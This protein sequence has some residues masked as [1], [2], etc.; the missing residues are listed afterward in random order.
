VSTLA[1]MLVRIRWF[2]L[3]AAVSFGGGM[4]VLGHLVRLRRRLTPANVA[5]ASGEAAAAWLDRTADA[6]TGSREEVAS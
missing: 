6:I 3:G 5:R 4:V 1:P 2:L